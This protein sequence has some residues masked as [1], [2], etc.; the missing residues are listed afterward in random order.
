MT[1]KEAT[2]IEKQKA[3]KLIE[4]FEENRLRKEKESVFEQIIARFFKLELESMEMGIKFDPENYESKKDNDI[5]LKF[6]ETNP[7]DLGYFSVFD[8][9]DKYVPQIE[10]NKKFYYPKLAHK[11]K[12]VR[13]ETIKMLLNTLFHETEHYHQYLMIKNCESSKEAM[14]Y[15][16]DELIHSVLDSVYTK[17]YLEYATENDAAIKAME[18]TEE[19]VG[20]DDYFEEDKTI[21]NGKLMAGEYGIYKYCNMQEGIY[22]CTEERDDATQLIME[23]VL[24]DESKKKMLLY[25]PILLKEYNEDFTRKTPQELITNMK[26]EISY[27]RGLNFLSEV[28]KEK[29]VKDVKEMYYEI[30]NRTFKT[31]TNT[32]LLD[33]MLQST[34]K[35]EVIKLIQ[36]IHEYFRIQM[37]LKVKAVQKMCEAELK[38]D[39]IQEGTKDYERIM[40][41]GEERQTRILQNEACRRILYKDIQDYLLH[42]EKMQY[43]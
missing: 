39:D 25:Y 34:S 8:F 29:K 1:K 22:P 4:Y 41:E 35:T 9:D 27:I 24:P 15:A 21:K 30:F 37:I 16:R 12:F 31:I 26:G 43:R 32:T 42:E 18:R 40:E 28:Q 23:K 2:R 38:I 13:K 5:I 36:D 20:E 19:I 3:K 7:K 33:D 14:V 17:N 6:I 10:I 11:N